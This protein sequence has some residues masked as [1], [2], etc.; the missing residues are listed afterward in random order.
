MNSSHKVPANEVLKL[1]DKICLSSELNT[2]LQ[3]CRLLR[4]LIEESLSGREERL[5]GYSI[6]VD[7]FNKPKDFDPEMDPIV[8]IHA[9]RLR[10][11]LRLYFL[12]TGI[13]DRIRI[14]IPKGKYIPKYTV[15]VGEKKEGGNLKNQKLEARI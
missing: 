14:E 5:K 8:R 4:Y 1:V 15:R 13:N 9:G 7:V 3:L 10:R 2:K 12:E 6:G 11:M